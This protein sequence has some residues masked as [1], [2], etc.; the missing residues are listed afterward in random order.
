MEESGNGS[1]S[2]KTSAVAESAPIGQLSAPWPAGMKAKA[3]SAPSRK[4]SR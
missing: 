3:R 2:S 1:S 4:R